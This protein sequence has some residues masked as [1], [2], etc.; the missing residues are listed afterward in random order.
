MASIELEIRN[1]S[2]LHA[3]PAVTFVRAAAGSRST[4]RVANLS[5]AGAEADAR[6]ILGVLGLG[7]GAGDR[8]R[9]T[10]EGE[11][12]EATLAALAAL[13]EGGLGESL[14]G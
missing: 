9:V 6:S 13:V 4:I 12:A 2:G 7:V 11:D 10:A 3:R 8:I 5:R 1:P 14:P